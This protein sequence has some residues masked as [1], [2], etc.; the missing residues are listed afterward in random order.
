MGL[1]NSP[2]TCVPPSSNGLRQPWRPWRQHSIAIRGQSYQPS[3]TA[4]PVSRSQ[5]QWQFTASYQELKGRRDPRY[6]LG[7]SRQGARLLYLQKV[8]SKLTIKL[9]R[10]YIVETCQIVSKC[11]ETCPDWTK[12]FQIVCLQLVYFTIFYNFFKAIWFLL[13]AFFNSSWFSAQN[14]AQKAYENRINFSR[15][16]STL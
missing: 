16:Y 9:M 13:S 15:I 11:V 10:L 8:P 4:T 7:T 5:Q 6:L 12:S 14:S 2:H 1:K 3:F